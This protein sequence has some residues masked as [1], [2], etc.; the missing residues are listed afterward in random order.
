[1]WNG[2]VG[3]RVEECVLVSG[4]EGSSG[5]TCHVLF[6]LGTSLARGVKGSVIVEFVTP[7]LL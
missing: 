3:G 2:G 5:G 4:E 7:L 1:M 6:G